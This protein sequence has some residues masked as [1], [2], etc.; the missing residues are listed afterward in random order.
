LRD[1][2]TFPPMGEYTRLDGLPFPPLLETRHAR[3]RYG[4]PVGATACVGVQV[5]VPIRQVGIHPAG[6]TPSH[7]IGLAVRFYNWRQRSWP[8]SFRRVVPF[9]TEVPDALEQPHAR[10]SSA[11]LRRMIHSSALHRNSKSCS[12]H[13][14]AHST[15]ST[16]TN[17]ESR[18]VLQTFEEILKDDSG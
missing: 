5:D 7:R 6:G 10:R 3:R 2:P 9:A 17:D 14:R 11:V 1:G 4:Q 18:R 8:C 13:R 15:P 16:S 12:N